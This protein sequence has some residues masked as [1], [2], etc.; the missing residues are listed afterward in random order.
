LRF[1]QISAAILLFQFQPPQMIEVPL[2][3]IADQGGAIHFPALCR[4]VGGVQE[5]FIEYNLDS[6]H[7][8]L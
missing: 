5:F 6:T 1:G 7:R 8:G 3:S 2:Q 4:N